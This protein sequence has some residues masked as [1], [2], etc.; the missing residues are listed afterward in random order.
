MSVTPAPI[1]RG[2]LIRFLGLLLVLALFAA[3]DGAS[4]KSGGTNLPFR[5]TGSGTATFSFFPSF[6]G[7]VQGAIIGTH[8]GAGT[9]V[10]TYSLS[11]PAPTCGSGSAAQTVSA[12]LSAANGDEIDETISASVCASGV[13]SYDVSGT[14]TITGGTGRFADAS[15]DGIWNAHASFPDGLFTPGTITFAQDGSISY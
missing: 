8:M 10:G 9:L 2:S 3:P 1:A 6:G 5:V 7:T 13:L 15:G 12:V 11:G 14:Y 4:A